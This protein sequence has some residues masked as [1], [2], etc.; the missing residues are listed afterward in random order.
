MH[1][2]KGIL[3]KKFSDFGYTEVKTSKFNFP[4]SLFLRCPLPKLLYA[5]RRVYV[6]PVFTEGRN[7]STLIYAS[8]MLIYLQTCEVKERIVDFLYA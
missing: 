3:E 2:V 8:C 5:Y 6:R 4:H 7:T 1:T